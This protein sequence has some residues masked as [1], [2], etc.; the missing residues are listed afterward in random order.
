MDEAENKGVIQPIKK[1]RC[2]FWVLKHNK[3]V[4]V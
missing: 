2:W 4:A 1:K 3:I